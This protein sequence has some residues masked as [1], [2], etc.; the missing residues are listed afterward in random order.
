MFLVKL[1]TFS[2]ISKKAGVGHDNF[3]CNNVG[4]LGQSVA[5]AS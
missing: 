2:L 3:L 5:F 4:E 1:M